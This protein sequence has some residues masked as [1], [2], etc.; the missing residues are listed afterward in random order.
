MSGLSGKASWRLLA[1]V[2]LALIVT[3]SVVGASG[4]GVP[5]R[6]G[7]IERGRPA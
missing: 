5:L 2:G 7:V 4:R 1:C 6:S 3:G